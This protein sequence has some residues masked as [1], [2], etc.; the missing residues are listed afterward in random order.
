[1]P[2]VSE[3]LTAQGTLDEQNADFWDELCGTG[4]A[5]TLGIETVDP[6]SLHRFDDAYM[7]I[8]PYVWRYLE[9]ERVRGEEVLEI[10]LGFGTVGQLLAAAGAVYHG[11]DIAR[12]PVHMM[13][14]RLAWAGLAG[15]ERVQQASALGLPFEEAS[16]DRVVSI[17]CLHHT[18]DTAKGVS[19][20]CRVL[21]PG[22]RAVVMLY[23][24]HSLRQAAARLRA[25]LSRRRDRDEW[26]RGR[27]DADSAGQAAP[28][29]DYVSRADVR[30]MFAG[31][32]SVGIEVQNFDDFRRPPI[33]IPRERL[34]GN[35]ARVLG[36]D[37][38]VVA[39]KP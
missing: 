31:F 1:M 3:H 22:G 8:Y 29:V 15:G 19:E 32:S 16:F 7:A 2:F 37:L 13:R 5:R 23:N 24:R 12:G 35:V 25:A 20:V 18:G 27:Y 38:Y 28:H 26:L 34:L 30:R 14:Q 39:D 17:G 10:G 6:E 9:L 36:T 11:V 21:R 4:L 33:V